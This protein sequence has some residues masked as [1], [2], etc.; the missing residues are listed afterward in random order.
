MIFD[1]L[2]SLVNA[3][4]LH[5][6][7][8]RER[9]LEELMST[10][11]TVGGDAFTASLLAGIG[12]TES[13]Y[14]ATALNAQS[15]CCGIMQIHPVH[16]SSLGWSGSGCQDPF[17]NIAAGFLILRQHGLGRLP[18]FAVL[19]G[20]GGFTTEDPA[21]YIDKVLSR[22]ILLLPRFFLVR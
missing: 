10:F 5:L 11:H 12:W 2:I 21:D 18:I 1:V 20:Y 22:A 3:G 15:G 16:F 6:G 8:G 7:A 19:Q 14:V 9:R 13:D 17:N 4:P